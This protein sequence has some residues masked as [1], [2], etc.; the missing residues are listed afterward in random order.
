MQMLTS[1]PLKFIIIRFE[2]NIWNIADQ[3]YAFA[4]S[5]LG[6]S[7][8]NNSRE[9]ISYRISSSYLLLTKK[10]SKMPNNKIAT[11][12]NGCKNFRFKSNLE[13]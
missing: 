6:K 1:F 8:N 2:N 13:N 9:F 7:K 5:V 4:W 3:I 11:Y 10:L 12:L